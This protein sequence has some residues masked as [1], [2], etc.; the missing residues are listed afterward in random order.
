MTKKKPT[1]LRVLQGNPG[2]R[3]INKNEPQPP[4]GPPTPPRTLN[5]YALDE[6]NEFVPTLFA[7]GLI[8]KNDATTFALYCEAVKTW[9]LAQEQLDKEGLLITF[10]SGNTQQHPLLGIRNK[11][12]ELAYKFAC[13][14]G[15]GPS[16][17]SRINIEKKQ[18]E[19]PFAKFEK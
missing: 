2:K 15:L 9:K 19:N 16:C 10:K 13:E 18:T 12:M 17:R 5:G 6:W 14:F 11:A 1:H 8:T 4:A 3:K 7:Q